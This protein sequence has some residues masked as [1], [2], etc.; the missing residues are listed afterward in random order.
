MTDVAP[1]WTERE[2]KR[3]LF[4]NYQERYAVVTEVCAY[5]PAER[6]IDVLL[7]N[8]RER[9]AVEIKVSRADLLQD[10]KHPEKQQPWRELVHKHYYAVP[11]P[12]LAL[13]QQAVPLTSGIIVV[14]RQGDRAWGVRIAR[15]ASVSNPSP[16]QIPEKAIAALYYRLAKL[17]ASAKGLS[18]VGGDQPTEGDSEMAA[19]LARTQRDLEIAHRKIADKDDQIEGWKRR[20]AAAGAIPCSHCGSSLLPNGKAGATKRGRVQDEW[21]HKD[22]TAE[23]VCI[24]IRRQALRARVRDGGDGA[25]LL[26]LLGGPRE[27]EVLAPV[28]PKAA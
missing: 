12:L 27:A 3:A 10:V 16:R 11:D 1:A 5:D 14:T 22:V 21:R 18:W 15:P 17:E 4:F 9:R 24:R 23:D 13:A 28:V 6:R 8:P 26:A 20:L 25:G 7:F 19:K 2:M